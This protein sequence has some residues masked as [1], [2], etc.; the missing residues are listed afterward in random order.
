MHNLADTSNPACKITLQLE[1]FNFYKKT[2][3]KCVKEYIATAADHNGHDV[4]RVLR[5]P[6]KHESDL[7]SLAACCSV[8]RTR[9]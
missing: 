1:S 2:H 4:H 9:N 7:R 3:R 6:E 5:G 8:Q